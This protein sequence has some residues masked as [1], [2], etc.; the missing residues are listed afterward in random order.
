MA[1]WFRPWHLA[2]VGVA[3]AAAVILANAHVDVGALVAIVVA[4]VLA[5]RSVDDRRVRLRANA[6]GLFVDGK[7]LVPAHVLSDGFVVRK[8]GDPPRLRLVDRFGVTRFNVRL[9]SEAHG[10]TL[11]RALG[12]DAGHKSTTFRVPNALLVVA[13]FVGLLPGAILLGTWTTV[14]GDVKLLSTLIALLVVGVVLR[15]G[16]SRVTVGADG[17]LKRG[18]GLDSFVPYGWIER[19]ETT[20]HAILL[21][22]TDGSTRTIEAPAPWTKD[23]FKHPPGPMRDIVAARIEQ[24]LY[25]F[26]RRATSEGAGIVMARGGRAIPDWH[27]AITGRAA[28]HYRV[29]AAPAIPAED[30]WRVAEDPGAEETARA[31]AAVALRAHEDGALDDV[32]ARLRAAARATASPRVRVALEAVADASDEDELARALDVF[33][34]KPRARAG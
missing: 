31:G 22:L 10:R 2:A 1:R 4:A 34:E 32:K 30:L 25:D 15:F 5:G 13:P 18:I 16:Y 29:A 3:L 19:V 27:A 8:F 33:E 20:P 24:A 21:R 26:R 17:V 23:P 11:L 12:L 6:E 14:D 7:R 9:E 28:A